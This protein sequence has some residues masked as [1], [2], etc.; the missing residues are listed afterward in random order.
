VRG[1]WARV[2]KYYDGRVEGLSGKVAR[3]IPVRHVSKQRP[4]D[5]ERTKVTHD[6]RISGIPKPGDGGLTKTDIA[7]LYRGGQYFLDSG[8]C[9]LIEYGDKST[10]KPNTYFV[11]CGEPRNRFFKPSDLPKGPS[12]ASM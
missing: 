2:S 1:G 6:P 5:V 8:Q 12:P 3:W 9:K 10:S 4:A 7:I 11:N